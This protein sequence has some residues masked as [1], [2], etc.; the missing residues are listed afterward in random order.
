MRELGRDEEAIE[1]FDESIA[2][3]PEAINNIAQK[4]FTLM[5]LKRW[6]EAL[7]LW[8]EVRSKDS[9]IAPAYIQAGIALRELGRDEEIVFIY[10]ELFGYEYDKFQNANDAKLFILDEIINLLQGLFFNI[11]NNS[12]LLNLSTKERPLLTNFLVGD[13]LLAGKN[14]YGT[15]I[16]VSIKDILLA[17]S[18]DI[19]DELIRNKSFAIISPTSHRKIS[20]KKLIVI[21]DFLFAYSFEEDKKLG[22]LFF[23]KHSTEPVFYYMPLEQKI[24]RIGGYNKELIDKEILLFFRHIIEYAEDLKVYLHKKSEK[25]VGWV[26]NAHIGHHI[27]NDLSALERLYGSGSIIKMDELII[28]NHLKTEIY[29]EIDQIFSESNLKVNRDLNS[30][31]QLAKY[32]YENNFLGIKLGDRYI[33]LSLIKRIRGLYSAKISNMKIR[34]KYRF[35][36]K[37]SLKVLIGL[38]FENRTWTNQVEGIK[39]I[40]RYL[41]TNYKGHITII[42]D[43]HNVS[44]DNLIMK[45]H[46][47]KEHDS[48]MDMELDAFKKIEESIEDLDNI[49]LVSAIGLTIF[50][51]LY[52]VDNSDFFIAPWGAGLVKYKWFANLNGIIFTSKYNLKN[53]PDLKIYEDKKIREGATRCLYVNEKYLEDNIPEKEAVAIN[54]TVQDEYRKN[55]HVNVEGIFTRIDQILKNNGE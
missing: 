1:L 24:Y 13:N 29:G 32:I 49:E 14:F 39:E 47:E 52:L 41:K 3:H 21:N 53:K 33:S 23:E 27:W 43:G 40:I 50:E 18:S 15:S 54:Q 55:F 17:K 11:E 37:A 35:L 34:D 26:R 31:I 44:E 5:K 36:D 10:V 45:S 12:A 46:M 2:L 8:S 28:L 38:R 4:A 48:I 16:D 6:E 25:V 20:S 9:S 7:E 30:H 19:Q 22:F 51:N 42:I